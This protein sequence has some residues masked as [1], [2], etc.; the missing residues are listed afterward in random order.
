MKQVDVPITE[1]PMRTIFHS[2]YWVEIPA[3]EYHVGLSHE[4]RQRIYDRVL[5]EV[6]YSHLTPKEQGLIDSAVGKICQRVEMIT[7]LYR[8]F[9]KKQFAKYPFGSKVLN[10]EEFTLLTSKPLKPIFHSEFA[11]AEI[12]LP[13]P[14][15]VDTFYMAKF[16][17]TQYQ[18]DELTHGASSDNVPGLLDGPAERGEVARIQ[19]FSVLEALGCRVP[20]IIEW[21]K[22]AR[23]LDGRLYPW[24]NEWDLSRG[25]F[26][27]GQPNITPRL[28]G[29]RVD[30]FP[31]GVSPYGIWGMAG[32]LPEAV[33]AR[34]N[35]PDVDLYY[36]TSKGC[37]TKEASAETAW[38]DHIVV[39]PGKGDWVSL[40]LVLDKWPVQQWHGHTVSKDQTS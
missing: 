40:R 22:A 17:L 12:P 2:D 3:G 39:L 11:L 21:G 28:G 7:A 10:D 15:F 31:R 8:Q 25:Y 30:K 26:Y 29:I 19:N 6:G 32:A 9:L 36:Y 18:Y 38:F 35:K 4:Q 24:G 1:H 20:T 33:Q 13:I 16:P 37:H 14:V 5:D 23:G 27:R 34:Q